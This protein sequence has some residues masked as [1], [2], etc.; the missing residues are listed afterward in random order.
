MTLI[1]SRNLV[2]VYGDAAR[3]NEVTGVLSEAIGV[4]LPECVQARMYGGSLLAAVWFGWPAESVMELM[5]ELSR[6]LLA[7]TFELYTSPASPDSV[8]GTTIAIRAGR[9]IDPGRPG[10]HAMSSPDSLDLVAGA[11]S[12]LDSIY[13]YV[14]DAYELGHWCDWTDPQEIGE[15]DDRITRIKSVLTPAEAREVDE[16]RDQHRERAEKIMPV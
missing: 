14:R 3:S 5:V 16:Y 10:D 1:A 7:E 8:A 4:T 13:S 12:H 15:H 2:R 9:I 6:Q 11:K